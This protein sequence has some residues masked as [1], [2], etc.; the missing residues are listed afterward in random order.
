[1]TLSRRTL[2]GGTVVGVAGG[3][4]SRAPAAAALAESTADLTAAA[5]DRWW[6]SAGPFAPVLTASLQGG[7]FEG[8]SGPAYLNDHCLVRGPDGWHLFS[9]IG[10]RPAADRAPDSEL[11]R[12]LAHYVAPAPSGPWTRVVDALRVDPTYGE[13]HLWAPHVVAVDG[14]W[15]MFYAAG[16]SGGSLICRATS[17]D[18][19]TWTRDPAGPLFRGTVAR[20]PFV[21]RVEGM[22][23]GPWVMYY[24][25]VDAPGGHHVVAAR[26]SP[27]LRTWS[28]PRWVL[29]DPSTES[30]VSVTESPQVI[31]RDG[32]FHL[33]VGPRPG[34]VGTT[35]L[36][37]R[38]PLRFELTEVA[39]G[40]PG[41]AVEV[42]QD[43]DRWWVSAAGWWQRGLMLAPLTWSRTPT[44][45]QSPDSPAAGLGVGDR[46]H[47]LALAA[48]RSALL[49]RAQLDG[50]A[51]TWGPWEVF[52][53]PAGAVPTLARDADGR[54]EVFSLGP[55]GTSLDHRVQRADGGWE[56]WERFGGP[57]G[58]APSVAADAAGRLHVVALGPDGRNLAVRRQSAPG[59]RTWDPWDGA[60]SGP[61]GGPPVLARN[62]DGRLEVLV[63]GPGGG[64]L[65]HRWQTTASGGAGDW[66]AWTTFG[67]PAAASPRVTRDAAGRLV[68]SAVA[69]SGTGS[70]TRRQSAP[71]AGWDAWRGHGGWTSASVPL[72]RGPRGVVSLDLS[73]G[74]DLLVARLQGADGGWGAPVVV[75]PGG[76]RLAGPPTAALDSRG[77]LRLWAVDL[78]GRLLATSLDAD[79]RAAAW[80][81]FGDRP[82]AAVVPGVPG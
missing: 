60:F 61:V 31:E 70:F 45:W 76:T 4:A 44:P 79:L 54:L 48:D 32:W 37:S 53:G 73:P 59:S 56:P 9:I 69:P 80:T 74:G 39:G 7:G 14:G 16:G 17:R 28:A 21:R 18:L 29:V 55:G 65:R 12:T 67:T 25:E 50:A 46:L 24:T 11:E 10:A 57:A 47:V 66:S 40:V 72:V 81:T 6:L 58:A 75:G 3:L 26:T 77:V 1:M 78:D 30:T 19:R 42:V 33:L 68:V 2:L 52:G 13:Q 8:P 63:L 15:Q 51:D 20:D 36:R 82:V 49:H 64:D 23:G 43:G 62:A 41:H 38:D 22:P 34:Y 5:E 35:V 27:D 71:S